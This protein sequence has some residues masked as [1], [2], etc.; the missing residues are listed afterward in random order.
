MLSSPF[1]V[2]AEVFNG[3][4]SKLIDDS[5]EGDAAPLL[6]ELEVLRGK[7]HGR[8]KYAK[9]FKDEAELQREQ[10][11]KRKQQ[12]Q[13]QDQQQL[14]GAE[15]NNGPS[16]GTSAGEVATMLDEMT[17][18]GKGVGAGAGEKAG[19]TAKGKN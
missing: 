17:I 15:E 13:K 18:G 6:K 14:Q 5:P 19:A 1:Q 9:L 8:F 4:K 2:A 11:E 16:T 3:V 7:L 12:Q 10:D